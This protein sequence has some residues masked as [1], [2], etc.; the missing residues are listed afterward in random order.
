MQKFEYK[1]LEV[2]AAGGFLSGGGVVNFQALSDKLNEYGRQG[3]E[4]IVSTD[5]NRNYGDTRNVM[6]ILKRPLNDS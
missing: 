3:W 4:V 6:I 1:V 2:N 5:I